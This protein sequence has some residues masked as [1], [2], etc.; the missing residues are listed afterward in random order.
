MKPK[1]CSV[2]FFLLLP[3]LFSGCAGAEPVK[4]ENITS[5][6]IVIPGLTKEYN[7]LFLTDTHII[8]SDEQEEQQVKDYTQSRLPVFNTEENKTSVPQLDEWITY[9]NQQKYDGLLLGGDII[10]FPSAA[11]IDYLAFSLKKLEIPY[12]YTPGNHD[13]TYPWEYMTEKGKENYLSLLSPYMED[14]PAIHTLEYE[15]FIIVA[16]NNSSNQIDPDALQT[17]KSIL[18]EGK[19]VIVLMHVPLYTDSVLAKSKEEWN[20]GVVLGGGIHGGI[21]PD[22]VSTE[23]LQLTLAKTSP[24]AAILSG[25]V[26]LSDTSEVLGDKNIPQITGDAGYKGIGT[27]IHISGSKSE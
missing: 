13:W 21:Y 10:D 1:V 5:C 23:F 16:I 25:H 7:F 4:A 24:V 27:R 6:D 17:Y 11:N 22:A 9:A 3:F 19:P 20:S 2:L 15:D 18:S 8:I 14:N 12:L 26:H